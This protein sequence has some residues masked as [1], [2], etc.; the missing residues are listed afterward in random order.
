MI[1]ELQD[2]FL[3][4]RQGN[5]S[6]KAF[7]WICE[8]FV[9]YLGPYVL[10]QLHDIKKSDRIF[11]PRS[12]WVMHGKEKHENREFNLLVS[13]TKYFPLLNWS[14]QI[15]NAAETKKMSHFL[16]LSVMSG[17]CFCLVYCLRFH[18]LWSKDEY[19][20][21]TDTNR[22]SSLAW[23]YQNCAAVVEVCKIFNKSSFLIQNTDRFV[24]LNPFHIHSP[25]KKACAKL[26]S[27]H[28]NSSSDNLGMQTAWTED[29]LS[30]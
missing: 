30:L 19:K 9:T 1:L 21:Q 11:I 26:S 12:S 10:W 14:S 16:L 28:S 3:C 13:K 17:G 8:D 25:H 18:C 22:S 24:L 15:E 27:A 5:D 7:Q 2:V 20:V 23:R 6:K 4:T 29:T